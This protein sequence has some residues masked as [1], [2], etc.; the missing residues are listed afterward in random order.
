MGTPY[1]FRVYFRYGKPDENGKYKTSYVLVTEINH[2]RARQK[3]L[4]MGTG[5]RTPLVKWLNVLKLTKD[6]N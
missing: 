1:I 5:E 6:Q 2:T 4:K 3:A